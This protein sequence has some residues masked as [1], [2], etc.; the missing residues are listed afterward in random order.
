M[1]AGIQGPDRDAQPS[2]ERHRI[3]D[4]TAWLTLFGDDNGKGA[5]VGSS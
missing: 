4:V 5:A 3:F 2:V 1:K